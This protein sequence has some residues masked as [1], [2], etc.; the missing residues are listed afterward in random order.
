MDT[1]ATNSELS[2][3]GEF[4]QSLNVSG[5]SMTADDAVVAFREY[6]EQ[7]AQFKKELQPALDELDAGLG[8]ELNMR[9]IYER[10]KKQL[11][12]EGITD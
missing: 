1:Q 5:K 6:Q 3:F 4:I 2:A 12:D 7:L 9:E 11:A 10:V 8:T